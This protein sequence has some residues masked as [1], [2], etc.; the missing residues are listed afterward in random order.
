[1]L[2]FQLQELRREN[3]KHLAYL[4]IPNIQIFQKTR[5]V[6]G[7]PLVMHRHVLCF[8]LA[9]SSNQ[10]CGAFFRILH[11]SI[12]SCFR[13]RHNLSCPRLDNIRPRHTEFG[14]ACAN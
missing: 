7:T 2:T 6:K 12:Q 4:V 14:L 5:L 9:N 11:S 10:E 8:V 3:Y 1:M 13:F